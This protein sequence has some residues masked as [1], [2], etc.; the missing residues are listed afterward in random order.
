MSGSP[1]VPQPGTSLQGSRQFSRFKLDQRVAVKVVRDG[2]EQTL[3]G[4]SNDL[5]EG[6]LGATLAGELIPGD[7]VVLEF[8]L[9]LTRDPVRLQARVQYRL[10]F[11]YG[12][13][14]ITL[15]G[16][17]RSA[18]VKLAGSLPPVE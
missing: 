11:R 9:P 8:W 4:R 2:S 7:I 15:S 14:F 6:G 13:A 5:S 3:R 18:I 10:G 1:G 16:E 17:Q 12:L